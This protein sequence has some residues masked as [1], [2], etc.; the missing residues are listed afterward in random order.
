M[1]IYSPL[2]HPR[3]RWVC[4]FIGTDLEKFS[5]L[6]SQMEWM[7]AVRIREQ[8]ADKNITIRIKN[9]FLTNM[10]L[11]TSHDINLWTGVVFFCLLVD[12]C[13]V[14]ICL[15]SHSDGT[16]SLQRIHW[17]TSDVT[18]NFSKSVPIKKQTHLDLGWPE[19]TFSFLCKLFL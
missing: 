11:F 15:D 8:T 12:Y 2:G 16:H 19:G 6:S 1:K 17:W 3:C 10:Q 5:I 9:V 4:F 13:D 18:L 7:G 14:F